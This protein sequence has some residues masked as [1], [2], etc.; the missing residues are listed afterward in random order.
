MPGNQ[1]KY[2]KGASSGLNFDTSCCPSCGGGGGGH[3][4]AIVFNE[5]NEISSVPA[6]P[7]TLIVQFTVPFSNT[8]SLSTIEF[9]GNN[10]AYYVMY[11]D[12][13][14]KS[15]TWTWFS[16]PMSDRWSY[17]GWVISAGTVISVKVSHYRPAPGTFSAKITG[18]LS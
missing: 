5:F 10:I 7:E 1:L 15:S 13:T 18:R 12:S 8:A 11:L 14:K 16:G 3:S 2:P 9:S 17:G 4:K 6:G